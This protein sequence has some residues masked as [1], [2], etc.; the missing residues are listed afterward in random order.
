MGISKKDLTIVIVT[1]Q[2]ENVIDDCINSIDNNFPTSVEN[3]SNSNLRNK[4]K[5]NLTM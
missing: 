4:L 2:S 3:S 5:K 1:F